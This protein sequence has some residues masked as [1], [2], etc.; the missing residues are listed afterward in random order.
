MRQERL[1]CIDDIDFLD[2]EW[3]QALFTAF[4]ACKETPT[5]L[6]VSAR[7]PP[8]F[9]DI[10]LGDLQSRLQSGLMLQ[11]KDLNDSE[12]LSLL[13]L[14]AENRNRAPTISFT[15]DG[16]L[17]KDISDS[18]VKQSIAIR[19]DNFYAWRCL[20]AFGIN[21]QDGVVRA[22]MVHYNNI[23]D[24]DKI[25]KALENTNILKNN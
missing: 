16:I 19:N 5:Q 12:K 8:S 2:A 10:K 6:I 20:K 14:R 25:I 15:V 13:K 24:V 4:N 22:S 21:T 11:I 9:L 17:S 3:E 23:E 18:L 7:K 1:V